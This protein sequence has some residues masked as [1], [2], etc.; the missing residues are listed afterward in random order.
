[1][2]RVGE[3]AD[4]PLEVLRVAR[5]DLEEIVGLARDVVTLLHLG[6]RREVRRQVVRC[7]PRR[8]AHPGEG[9]DAAAHEDGVDGRRVARDDTA[10]LELLYPLVDRWRA[11]ADVGPDV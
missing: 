11:D 8:L 7:G 5:P 2:A 6:D 10:G 3:D 9:E 4:D 1:M